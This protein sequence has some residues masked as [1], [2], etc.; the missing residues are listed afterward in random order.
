MSENAYWIWYGGDWELYHHML[1][2][3]RRQEIGLDIPCAWRVARPEVKAVFYRKSEFKEDCTVRVVSRSKG[4][5]GIAGVRYPV[6]TDVEVKKGTV[7]IEVELWDIESFPS[8][9]IDSEQVVTDGEWTVHC[10][11]RVWKKAGFSK[12]YTSAE[13]D[14]GVFPFKYEKLTPVSAE[15]LN[16]GTLYDFG[17]ET[18][19]PVT[20][21]PI[22]EDEEVTLIYG[23]SV[24]EATDYENAI[25]REK[26]TTASELKRPAR[27]FRY[28]FAKSTKSEKVCL[29]AEYEYLHL[30]DIASFECDD[31]KIKEIWDLCS[32]TF[33]LNSREFFLDGIKRDRWVWSGDAYQSFLINRYFYADDDITERTITALFGKP[34]YFCHV[35]TINDYS[36]FLI[37]AVWEHYIATGKKDFVV[38]LW[39]K[40]K[41]L[42]DF[43][44]SRL[45]EKGYVVR[46]PGDWI[47][48]DWGDVDKSGTLCAEQILLWRVY[49]V[50]AELCTLMGEQSDCAERAEKL[51]GNIKCDYW[52][53][54]KGAFIDCFDGESAHVS[55]Q[56]NILAILFDFVDAETA[57][58]LV[59]NVLDN[60]AVTPITTPY[61]KLYELIVRCKCGDVKTMQ[62]YLS[63]YWGGMLDL[64]A[65]S[66]WE[67]YDPTDSGTAHYGMYGKA[68]GKSLCHA[69]G[70]GPIYLL[71]R[72]VA[73]VEC[74]G[75]G[76][77]SFTVKPDRGLFG[78]FDAVVPVGKSRVRVTCSESSVTVFSEAPGGTLCYNGREYEIPVG[79]ELTVEAEK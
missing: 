4:F 62:K 64:G 71:G 32:R 15:P 35:N 53:E 76:C 70:S 7:E 72:F 79:K 16:G 42:Y 31:G 24:E 39:D 61:F 57:K 46:R 13:D 69:W 51:A 56:T 73:G 40:I 49:G 75:L 74:T 17:C 3:G 22:A 78:S 29:T 6:N 33:H 30:E 5:A 10:G 19:G 58:T 23:E 38:S 45:D 11:D 41:A 50:M 63:E 25:V 9:F 60:P 8:M 77:S 12:M 18:F 20:L 37:I 59:K 48:I 34:A 55:M 26:L 14:P 44:V 67:Q 65:T 52:S 28:I 68:F 43:I 2:S 27:A 36:A 47:F 21:A 1:L 54:G 66:V